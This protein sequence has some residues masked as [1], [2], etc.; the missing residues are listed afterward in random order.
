MAGEVWLITGAQASGKSTVA[1]RL[2]ARFE[3]G[4]HVRGGQFYR[5]V[6]S[7]WVHFDG[8]DQEEARRLLELRYR[9]SAMVARE[10][11]GAGFASVVQDNIYGADVTA[12]LSAVDWEPLRLVVL[13]PSVQ[14]I[15]QRDAARRAATGKTAYRGGFTPEINDR[16][17]RTTP[18]DVGLWVDSSEMDADETVAEILRRRD[19]ALVDRSALSAAG[20]AGH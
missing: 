18:A 4:V 12:W 9:L 16:H 3:R 13:R 7:G 14:V 15:G 5:W 11:A 8:P 20:I 10:Y 1:D 6:L 17:L 2:A 19:E